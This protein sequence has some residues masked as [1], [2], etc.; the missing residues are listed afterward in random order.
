MFIGTADDGR[1]VGSA[2]I[3]SKDGHAFLIERHQAV[4]T[5]HRDVNP[6]IGRQNNSSMDELHATVENHQF[7]GGFIGALKFQAVAV[8]GGITVVKDELLWP[9]S[10]T[11]PVQP[12]IK[13]PVV[14]LRK[15]WRRVLRESTG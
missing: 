8:L 12:G 7:A 14:H 10:D 3:G 2:A 15:H 6:L 4:L 13:T 1:R 11:L 5:H 9:A